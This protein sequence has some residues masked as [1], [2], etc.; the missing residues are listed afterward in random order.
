MAEGGEAATLQLLL[1]AGYFK[2]GADNT[3]PAFDKILFGL[4]WALTS[5]AVDVD[6]DISYADG[7]E[8]EA[9]LGAKLRLSEAIERALLSVACPTPLQAHQIQGLDWPALFPCVQW[10][11]RRVYATR[12]EFGDERRRSALH[13]YAAFGYAPLDTAPQERA[14]LASRGAARAARFP[15][16]R[17]LRRAAGSSQ[18]TTLDGAVR[19]TCAEYGQRY[20]RPPGT[21]AYISGSEEEQPEL[22]E[23]QA[24]V[25][26]TPEAAA[27]LARRPGH[28]APSEAD[29]RLRRLAELQRQVQSA[30]RQLAASRSQ[31][32]AAEQGAAQAAEEEKAR[33]DELAAL[34]AHNARCVSESAQLLSTALGGEREAQAATL[35]AALRDL[36]G[37]KER[38]RAFK[39]RCRAEL[40]ELQLSVEAL[41]Q[42]GAAELPLSLLLGEAEAQRCEQI[43]QAH[44]QATQRLSASRAALARRALGCQLLRRRLNELP[45]RPE[46]AQYEQRFVELAHAVGWKLEETRRF[47]SQ[48]NAAAESLRVLQAELALLNKLRTQYEAVRGADE[49]TRTAFVASM[50]A[51]AQG[52]QDS[53]RKQEDKLTKEK[54]ALAEAQQAQAQALQRNRAYAAVLAALQQ[55]VARGEELRQRLEALS[56]APGAVE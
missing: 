45:G 29:L 33:R 49:N 43:A 37:A 48:Y 38:E 32:A 2:A 14:R 26:L 34:R 18:P 30:E 7:D 23:A 15:A 10:L 56:V 40:A 19:S 39:E 25:V 5:A 12:A 27:R 42:S 47:F 1:E 21:A 8:S 6:V 51:A 13:F 3:S 41:E 16:T 20:G 54:G 50:A 53:L 22:I 55:E 9:S 17:R 11:V 44:A 28:E 52:V 4:A 35:L 36:Q 31:Q 24:D 46:L